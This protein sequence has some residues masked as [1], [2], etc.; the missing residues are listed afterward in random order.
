[1]DL[2]WP[3]DIEVLAYHLFE[4][5]TASNGPVQ[6]LSQRELSLE[7]GDLV[8]VTGLAVGGRVG[9]RQEPQPFA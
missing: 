6:R 4:E 2:A 9:M 1:L 5:H 3:A 7:N 8:T